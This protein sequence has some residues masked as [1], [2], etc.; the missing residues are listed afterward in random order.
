[1]AQSGFSIRDLPKSNV[2][3][4]NLPPDPAYP[5]PQDS[6]NAPR[7]DLG[8]RLVK[9]ALFTYVRPENVLSPE[10]LAVSAAAMHDLGL[11]PGADKEEFLQTMAGNEIIAWD[12]KTGEGIYPWAQCYGGYQ[13]GQW[14]GQ[15]GD[16]RAL[17]LFETTNPQT[18]KRY[19]V[20]LKGAGKTPYSRFADGKAVLRSSI[21]EF[22]VS[23]ALNAL[24]IPTSR[25][26]S[27]VLTPH[28]KVQRE[29]IE[30]GAIVCRFAESWLRIGTFD[31]L[32]T[33]GDRKLLRQLADYVAEHVFG[34][35]E[36]LP[37]KLSSDVKPGKDVLEAAP[38]TQSMRSVPTMSSNSVDSQQFMDLETGVPKLE[39]Q[40][41]GKYAEN[42]YARLY[43]EIVRRNARTVALWQ[44]YGFTNGVL[45][46]DNTSIF[47]L[48]MD[49][50]PFAFIDVFDPSYTPNHDDHLGRYSYRNQPTIIWWNLVRLGEA[51]GELIGAG[52]RVDEEVFAT[53]GV[54]KVWVDELV[55]RAETLIA[56]AGEEYKAVFMEE[57]RR[58]MT[59]RLGLKKFKESDFNE[60]YSEFLDLMEAHQLDFNQSF[61]RLGALHVERLTGDEEARRQ[62]ASTLFG[63]NGV[64]E[65]DDDVA[66]ARVAQWLEKW[67][68]RVVEDWGTGPEDARR[69]AMNSVNPKFIPKGWIL[70]E[71]IERVEK[72]SERDILDGVMRMALAPFNEEWGW[73]RETEERFCGDIPAYKAGMQ[74]SCSS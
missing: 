74:C 70:D 18:N 9:G 13:F 55:E 6:H 68:R 28:S 22:I 58:A 69:E 7:E 11:R 31:L 63:K 30:P 67:S 5:T 38:H 14:A 40:G 50:G 52:D 21:R 34:G 61:R 51:F 23:E 17:S 53:Q 41:S 43:R 25:A 12:E 26:L 24:R 46:T 19:E 33:R 37:A 1:M 44:A 20:Q 16:G 42:R 60:L 48:S 66:R 29:R 32:R 56:A 73:D 64:L 65:R 45:N 36:Q 27:L 72:K 3:T 57:Y 2:F 8:P 35:W 49:F 54:E 10:L 62:A 59:A 47:G 71:I 4:A 39:T 15:L